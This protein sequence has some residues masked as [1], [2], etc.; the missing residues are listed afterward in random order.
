MTNTLSFE[1]EILATRFSFKSYKA[2]ATLRKKSIHMYN[3]ILYLVT[4]E[5]QF[6]GQNRIT[7]RWKFGCYSNSDVI[8]GFCL[9]VGTKG[10]QILRYLF[11]DSNHDRCHHNGVQE[12]D[13]FAGLVNERN[14]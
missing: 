4:E 5:I 10:D 11:S 6:Y 12:R 14:T 7:S 1:R 2:N 8:F 9:N 3:L 13:D